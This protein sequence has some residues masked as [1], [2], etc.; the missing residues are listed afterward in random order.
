M[1]PSQ[2]RPRQ[3]QTSDMGYV[4]LPAPHP[5]RPMQQQQRDPMDP[6]T[7]RNLLREAGVDPP[8]VE[9]T[10]AALRAFGVKYYDLPEMRL[11]VARSVDELIAADGGRLDWAGAKPE[12][13]GTADGVVLF[14]IPGCHLSVRVFPGDLHPR[15]RLLYFDFFD[16]AQERPVNS[17]RGFRICKLTAVAQNSPERPSSL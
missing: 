12:D 17:P 10:D 3:Q 11:L 13:L 4:C 16:A 5:Q 15:N 1:P 14:A 2:H 9:E 6:R 8:T 7:Q